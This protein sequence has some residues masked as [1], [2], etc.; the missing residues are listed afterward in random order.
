V[1][2]PA[3]CVAVVPCLN[4]ARTIESLVRGV[5]KYLPHVIVVDDGSDD[6]TSAKARGAGAEVLRHDTSQ[7]KGASL[8]AGWERARDR[9]FQWA[10]AL[11]GD[12]QHSPE[13][14][15]QFFAR[16]E[17]RDASLI[18]GD[19][20]SNADEMPRLRRIVNRW[21]SSK[22]SR[23]AHQEF[24]DSQCGFRLV[25]LD[26]VARNPLTANHFEIESEQ[27]LAFAA[28]DERISFVPI[29]VIY[30]TER[31]KIHPLRDTFRWFQW[32]RRWRAVSA[33][34]E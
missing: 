33:R 22:L 31:S 23:I 30:R 6:E 12:G 26:A 8:R 14:I 29:R 27:L 34:R 21:M 32:L 13:D 25:K 10:L 16:G 15:P 7:G 28:A 3:E 5:Q 2:W 24:P 1:N 11:D 4:E 9:G 17:R 20:M 18:I 19:R